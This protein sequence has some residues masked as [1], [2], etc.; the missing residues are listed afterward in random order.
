[1]ARGRRE[2]GDGVVVVDAGGKR[3]REKEVGTAMARGETGAAAG[4][5]AGWLCPRHRRE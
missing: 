4:V 3:E 5:G 2:G 1:M